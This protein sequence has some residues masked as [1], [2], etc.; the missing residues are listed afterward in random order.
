M[1]QK[2]DG[3]F[4]YIIFSFSFMLMPEKNKAIELAK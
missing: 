2:N 3:K 1:T 4:D